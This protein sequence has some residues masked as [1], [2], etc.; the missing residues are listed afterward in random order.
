M[1]VT[2]LIELSNIISQIRFSA[3]I[4]KIIS[5]KLDSHS[6]S[7]V[8]MFL[9]DLTISVPVVGLVHNT[10]FW[11]WQ[12]LFVCPSGLPKL[13]IPWI[14][15]QNFSITQWNINWG[16]TEIMVTIAENRNYMFH[17]HPKY[18]CTINA[19]KLCSIK[20]NFIS[21]TL[22]VNLAKLISIRQDLRTQMV[23]PD[24]FNNGHRCPVVLNVIFQ[25]DKLHDMLIVCQYLKE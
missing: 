19:L 1:W 12:D 2:C 14:K 15:H 21:P 4:I 6:T 17:R 9:C 20:H 11:S 22:T 3:V 24:L 23:W 8:M 5:K 18:T 7:A 13:L 25:I 16:Q 10:E